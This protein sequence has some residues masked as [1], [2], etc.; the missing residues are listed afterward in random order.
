[1]TCFTEHVRPPVD[2]SDEMLSLLKMHQLLSRVLAPAPTSPLNPFR[3]RDNRSVRE[4]IISGLRLTAGLVAGFL[5]LVLALGGLSTLPGGAPAY[6]RFGVYVS[7]SMICFASLIMLMTANRWAP[8]VPGFFFVP[9]LFKTLG[10]L[11]VGANSSS[12]YASHRVTRTE[13]AEILV[14][15]AVVIALTWRFVGNRPAP[16]TLLDRIALTFFILATLKQSAMAYNSPPVALISG[17]CALLIAWCVYRW[18]RAGTKSK[19][20]HGS[21]TTFEKLPND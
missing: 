13:A 9:A 5:V 7:W 3:G 2:K 19:R 11:L 17:L 21:S 4:Q 12:T 15:C 16:T 20:Q 10:I 18:G 6:G 8:F 14:V 1:M